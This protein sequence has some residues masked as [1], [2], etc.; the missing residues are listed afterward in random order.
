MHYRDDAPFVSDRPSVAAAV[1]DLARS[2]E[3]AE[4][5]LAEATRA[6]IE[7]DYLMTAKKMV[8][9][10]AKPAE[11]EWERQL[12][13]NTVRSYW[14]AK[15][16]VAERERDEAR[17][18]QKALLD[19]QNALKEQTVRIRTAALGGGTSEADTFDIVTELAAREKALRSLLECDHNANCA[20]L[21]RP[22]EKCDC[23]CAVARGMEAQS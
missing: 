16:V 1:L 7:R 22:G 12:E 6:D 21:V 14:V 3:A 17:G 23:P 2:A 18:R 10:E 8:D 13:V 19:G 5:K 9:R 20:A 4:A 15:L 11:V